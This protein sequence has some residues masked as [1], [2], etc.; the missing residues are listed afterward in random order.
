MAP[1]MITWG[2][3]AAASRVQPTTGGAN[4]VVVGGV[5]VGREDAVEI[6]GRGE[7]RT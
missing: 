6:G 3:S 2:V 1:M 7:G 4:G 5:G